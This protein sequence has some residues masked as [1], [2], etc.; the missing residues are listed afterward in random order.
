MA[1][2]SVDQLIANKLGAETQ[3][4]SLELSMDAPALAGACTVNLSCVYTYTLSW[5]GKNEPLPTEHNP[6]SVFERLFGDSGSTSQEARA[7]RLTQQSSI[8]DA[9]LEKLNDLQHS[10]GMEDRHLVA[11]LSD[12]VRDIGAGFRKRNSKLT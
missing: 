3:L 7:A 10:L 2:I 8:L 1:D 11:E 9:V 5:R 12:S 4:A 6:R